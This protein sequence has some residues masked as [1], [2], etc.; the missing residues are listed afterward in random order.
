MKFSLT[1]KVI[2]QIVRILS[3]FSNS[4]FSY[5]CQLGSVVSRAVR[6]V[7]GNSFHSNLHGKEGY[8][9]FKRV[10]LQTHPFQTYCSVYFVLFFFDYVLQAVVA[11]Y[12][13][14]S[15]LVCCFPRIRDWSATG[16]C[17]GMCSRENKARA[18]RKLFQPNWF[19]LRSIH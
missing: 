10:R 12:F 14:F 11:P 13:R 6:L 19:V 2:L 9:P 8:Q 5:S 1:R 15:K 17:I 3:M 7:A 18:A 16:P 4:V